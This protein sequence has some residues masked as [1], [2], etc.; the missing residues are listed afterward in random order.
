MSEIRIVDSK[1]DVGSHVG[2]SWRTVYRWI[3]EGLPVL[4]DGKFDLEQVD[5]WLRR[6]KGAGDP[7]RVNNEAGKSGSGKPESF[8]DKD[9][10]DKE[11]KKQQAKLRELDYRR[12]TGEL[13]ERSLI[14]AQ[15]IER[16]LVVKQGLRTMSR[17]MIP[18]L[19]ACQS[20]REMAIILDKEI[21]RL[22]EA[23]SRS[24]ELP[25]PN[26]EQ[27]ADG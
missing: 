25:Q 24:Y 26:R 8:D 15:Q 10:W 2:K 1:E 14:E 11:S 13:I 5:E 27:E 7:S 22:I 3:K 9:Y 20:E 6:R 12:R 17:R 23:F 18:H 19:F 21:N 4:P 16:I